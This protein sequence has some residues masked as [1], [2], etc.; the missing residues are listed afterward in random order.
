MALR[1]ARR[2][3]IVI[4]A[5]LVLVGLGWLVSS[6]IG[7][8]TDDRNGVPGVDAPVAQDGCHVGGCNN[9]LCDDSS[10]SFVSDCV[11][12]PEHACYR[13][14]YCARQP[15]GQ[16]GWTKTP[17]LVTCLRQYEVELP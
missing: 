7:S 1:I 4:I 16:C 10:A 6:W 11:A 17:K 13:S 5:A 8:R 2:T 12:K 9:E 15:D 3:T 14:A